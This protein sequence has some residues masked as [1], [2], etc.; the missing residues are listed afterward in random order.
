MTVMVLTI[1]SNHFFGSARFDG[2]VSRNHIVV[3]AA[4]PTE[5]AMVA[6]DVCH[7][8]CAVR[9]IG[10]TVHDNQGDGSHKLPPNMPPAAPL[11]S[12][13]MI[14]T[15]YN[16]TVFHFFFMLLFVFNKTIINKSITLMLLQHFIVI[17]CVAGIIATTVRRLLAFCGVDVHKANAG[18]LRLQRSHLRHTA[19]HGI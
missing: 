11:M 15:M 13:S 8:E 19:C 2:A 4:Q 7:A 6:V 12:N 18:F 17:S 14:R 1:C 3:A 9:L 10:G 5:G 16:S